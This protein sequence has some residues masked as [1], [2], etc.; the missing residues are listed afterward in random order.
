MVV[1]IEPGRYPDPN[2]L[3]AASVS[4]ACPPSIGTG[5]NPASLAAEPVL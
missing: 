1:S 4:F 2:I 5:R 3:G